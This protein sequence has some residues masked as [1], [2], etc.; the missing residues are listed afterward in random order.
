MTDSNC[1]V[2]EEALVALAYRKEPRAVPALIAEL[3][4]LEISYR[5]RE[6]A[7]TF[8]GENEQHE[9]WGPNDFAEALRKQFAL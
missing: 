7:E 4:Q 3:N 9:G 1:D 2:R 5:L 8:L 6:A